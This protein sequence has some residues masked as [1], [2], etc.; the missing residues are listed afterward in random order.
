MESKTRKDRQTRQGGGTLKEAVE[1]YARLME[2]VSRWADYEWKCQAA[3]CNALSEALHGG[4]EKRPTQQELEVARARLSP[5][6]Q[7]PTEEEV[8]KQIV[9]DRAEANTPNPPTTGMT[10]EEELALAC[11]IEQGGDPF[12]AEWE[13]LRGLI[14][15]SDLRDM[16]YDEIRGRHD[17]FVASLMGC[18]WQAIANA[19]RNLAEYLS[20]LGLS[21]SGNR[22][23][24]A[25]GLTDEWIAGEFNRHSVPLIKAIGGGGK[26]IY[27]KK[28]GGGGGTYSVGSCSPRSVRGW[29]K[30]YPDANTAEPIS[31]FHA[32]MLTDEKAIKAAAERWGR[33]YADY[34]KAFFEWR[35]R[36][37]FALRKDFRYTPNPTV[38]GV[39]V[40]VP[41]DDHS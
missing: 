17:T 6:G 15:L 22:R 26:P 24:R 31:G 39:T 25:K 38:H 37:K 14:T 11:S 21:P 5:N 35:K 4:E 3:Y 28:R 33:Y 36:N 40:A 8:I 30:K 9:R 29:L 18:D 1:K 32:E 10:T 20:C 13:V 23:E 12:P 19:A 2:R 27:E 16:V 34:A 7:T 41:A